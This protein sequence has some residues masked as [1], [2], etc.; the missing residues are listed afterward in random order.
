M[1]GLNGDVDK[2][3]A[4]FERKV[5]RRMV[6]GIEVNENWRK[7]YNKDL[8]QLF[9]DLD[10]ISFVGIGLVMLTERIVKVK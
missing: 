7:R 10:M 4:A 9:G 6:G 3:R 8:L 5:L 1:L 2:R